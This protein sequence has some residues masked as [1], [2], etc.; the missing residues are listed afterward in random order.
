MFRAEEIIEVMIHGEL[1]ACAWPQKDIDFMTCSPWLFDGQRG[2]IDGGKCDGICASVYN[3]VSDDLDSRQMSG[4]R[5][6]RAV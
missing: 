4:V 5:S 2:Y 1:C 3:I 6:A